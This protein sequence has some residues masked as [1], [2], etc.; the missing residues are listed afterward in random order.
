MHADCP[1]CERLRSREVTTKTTYLTT[2]RRSAAAHRAAAAAAVAEAYVNYAG[3][4]DAYQAHRATHG[5][6]A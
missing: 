6:D 3:A 5:S 4:R 1:E 2:A